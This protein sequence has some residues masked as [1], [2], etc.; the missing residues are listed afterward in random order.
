METGINKYQNVP[1]LGSE[2][3]KSESAKVKS[4]LLAVEL[5]VSSAQTPI[6]CVFIVENPRA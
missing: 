3:L 2:D 4:V 5:P 1:E 6:S